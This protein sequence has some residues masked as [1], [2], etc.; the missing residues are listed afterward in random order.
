VKRTSHRIR[1]SAAVGVGVALTIVVVG[2]GAARL[3]AQTGPDKDQYFDQLYSD[4]QLNAPDGVTP[5]LTPVPSIGPPEAWESGIFEE[6]EAPFPSSQFSILNRWQKD[7]DGV[8]IAVYAGSL[9]DDPDQGV[10]V[11]ATTPLDLSD[12]AW[13][14]YPTPTRSGAV[15][16]LAASGSVVLLQACAGDHFGFDIDTRS[17]RV[18][19]QWVKGD[20]G[21]SESSTSSNEL[22]CPSPTP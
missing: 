8:H 1:R 19:I 21:T 12:A 7:R 3:F 5:D 15:R 17:Y 9:G 16:I 2:S 4:E 14:L 10:V 13:S 18:T 11:V 6:Q 20:G 22:W